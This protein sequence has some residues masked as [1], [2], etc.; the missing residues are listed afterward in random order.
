MCW[1]PCCIQRIPLGDKGSPM[2]SLC[3]PGSDSKPIRVLFVLALLS[4][5]KSDLSMHVDIAVRDY[6]GYAHNCFVSP[7]GLFQENGQSKSGFAHRTSHNAKDI[8]ATG[9]EQPKKWK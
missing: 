2:K 5:S 7:F 8:H 9:C 3:D 6:N 4:P 1:W